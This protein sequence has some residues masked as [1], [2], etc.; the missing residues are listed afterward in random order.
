MNRPPMFSDTMP[1]PRRDEGPAI[2]ASN[3]EDEDPDGLNAA[4]GILSALGIVAGA[5]AA[6]AVI[7][8]LFPY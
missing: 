5:L 1:A 4:R 7:A 8:L 3:D 2:A 6:A